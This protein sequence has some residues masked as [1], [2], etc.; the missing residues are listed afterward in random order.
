[1]PGKPTDRPDTSLT[2]PAS[3]SERQE[4]P[5]QET[6]EASPPA[7]P[8]QFIEQFEQFFASAIGPARNPVFEKL[9]EDHITTLIENGSKND[10]RIFEDS[11]A[12]RRYKMAYILIG[13]LS[14]GLLTAYMM[15]ID[16]EL[17]KQVIQ[18]LIAV[19]GGFGAGYGYRRLQ[20]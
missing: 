1:M 7:P 5:A 8:Q 20:E 17:Y 6:P 3:E 11:K 9:N 2:K 18:L 4:A 10:G 14:F 13:L 19:G 12:D 15:P 16:K